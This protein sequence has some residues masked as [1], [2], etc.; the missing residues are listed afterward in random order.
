MAAPGSDT[1]VIVTTEEQL[2]IIVDGA[3]RAAVGKLTPDDRPMTSEEV[4]DFLG[5]CSKTVTT[6]VRTKGL[7]ARR[8][9]KALRFFRADVLRWLESQTVEAG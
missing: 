5:V 4:G 8:V 3:V 7:P 6:L 2:R 1:K 9:G